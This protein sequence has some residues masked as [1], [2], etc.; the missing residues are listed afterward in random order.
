MKPM[1][2]SQSRSK[3]KILAICGILA[4]ILYVAALVVGNILDPTYSQV[5]KTVSEL[6]ERGAPNRDLLNAI[7][8]IYNVLLSRTLLGSILG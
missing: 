6:I 4:P 3:S 2:T 5:G 1:T 7:F 8:I